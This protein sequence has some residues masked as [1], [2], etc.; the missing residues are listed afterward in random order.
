MFPALYAILDADQAGGPDAS[1]ARILS[2]AGVKLIQVRDKKASTRKLFDLSKRLVE[3][4][5]HAGVRVIVNDR[6]DIAAMIGA[7]GVHVGQE[8]L[9]VEAAPKICGSTRWVGVSTHS[10]QQLREANLTSADSMV[11]PPI[12]TSGFL[13]S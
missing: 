2:G 13:V 1:L 3:A 8:D 9:T 5:G 10:L 6:P 4:L 11:I 7:G 12:A